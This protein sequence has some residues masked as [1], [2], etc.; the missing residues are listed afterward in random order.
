MRCCVNAV[1][2]QADRERRAYV[3][4]GVCSG[5]GA[6]SMEEAEHLCRPQSVGDTG[7]YDCPGEGLWQDEDEENTQAKP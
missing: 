5:C 2:E 1:M 7:D 6:R 4:A 3:K